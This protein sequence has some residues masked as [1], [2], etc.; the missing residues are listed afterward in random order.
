MSINLLRQYKTEE[1]YNNEKCSLEEGTVCLVDENLE[2]KFNHKSLTFVDLGLPSS[3]L[4]AEKNIGACK[5]EDFGLYFA[6]CETE[7][8]TRNNY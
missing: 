6:W 4:W 7:G 5:L 8:Y 2:T 3:L 1:E